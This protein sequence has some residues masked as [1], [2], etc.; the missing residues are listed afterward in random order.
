MPEDALLLRAALVAD[1]A[2]AARRCARSIAA[3]FPHHGE[4]ILRELDGGRTS[5]DA[6]NRVRQAAAAIMS[7]PGERLTPL[8]RRVRWPAVALEML[9][10]A[11]ARTFWEF[12]PAS[13]TAVRSAI[14]DVTEGV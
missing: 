7:V 11:C 3:R 5:L 9:A 6:W 13:I 4:A 14:E 1:A 12:S 10:A 8:D 2:E